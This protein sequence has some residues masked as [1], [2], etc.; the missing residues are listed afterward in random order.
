MKTW[1]SSV[2]GLFMVTILIQM[3][4]TT[5]INPSCTNIPGIGAPV[6]I[7]HTYFQSFFKS[8]AFGNSQ[9]GIELVVYNE[10]NLESLVYRFIFKYKSARNRTFYVG[11][12]STIPEDQINEPN[13]EHMIVRFIQSSDIQDTQRLL[14]LYNLNVDDAR[15][16]EYKNK[17]WSYTSLNPFEINQNKSTANQPSVDTFESG[18]K[19]APPVFKQENKALPA[20]SIQSISDLLLSLNGNNNVDSNINN[21]SV[22][23]YRIVTT[24]STQNA[25]DPLKDLLNVSSSGNAPFP[26]NNLGFPGPFNQ[27][28]NM[29][30]VFN[31]QMSAQPPFNQN[32]LDN[33]IQVVLNQFKQSDDNSG[34]KNTSTSKHTSQTRYT[35]GSVLSGT[36]RDKIMNPTLANHN[37]MTG[38][39]G[40]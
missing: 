21:D 38:Q 35:L 19:T 5:Q 2:W 34:S 33:K 15:D 17:F 13:P 23:N 36:G 14:G 37:N 1:N 16:C 8:M 20:N 39:G 32:S 25:T 10:R 30:I 22:T 3:N 28:A 6:N 9:G 27:R 11:I 26:L 7:F 40:Q 24:T 12:L 4:R 18:V 31:N 29:N